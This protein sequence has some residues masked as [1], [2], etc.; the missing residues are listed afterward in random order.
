MEQN[1]N[2]I[3]T[4]RSKDTL[5]RLAWLLD[6]SIRVPGTQIRFGLDGL[7]GLIVE[8]ERATSQTWVGKVGIE[9]FTSFARQGRMVIPV[10]ITSPD[11]GTLLTIGM[12][13]SLTSTTFPVTDGMIP[14]Q[15]DSTNA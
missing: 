3:N 10:A 7:I 12:L 4:E 13:A 6:N 5:N 15:S 8:S 14:F 9:K 11:C 1:T 2:R